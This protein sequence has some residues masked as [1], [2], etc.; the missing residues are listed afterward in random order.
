MVVRY[1]SRGQR[2]DVMMEYVGLCMY[3]L[4][5]CKSETVTNAGSSSRP[6]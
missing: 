3:E 4:I 2:Y 6:R 1:H 5:R